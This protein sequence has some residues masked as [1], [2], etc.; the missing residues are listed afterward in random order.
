MAFPEAVFFELLRR[1]LRATPRSAKHENRLILGKPLLT[2]ELNR[3]EPV[4]RRKMHAGDMNF[5]VLRRSADVEEV[6]FFPGLNA[7]LELG[8]SDGFHKDL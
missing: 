7:G 4:E 6:E 5:R 8:G 2:R 1:L 3:V